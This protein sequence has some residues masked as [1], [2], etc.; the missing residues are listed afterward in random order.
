MDVHSATQ[1][2]YNMSQIRDKDTTPE[3]LIR[4]W[5]WRNGYR[6]RLH[7]KDLPGKPDIVFRK[8]RKVIFVHGCFWHKH[9]CDYFRWPQ[10]NASFWKD[11]ISSNVKR[12]EDMYSELETEGW[13]YLIIWEC[14]LRNDSFT[15]TCDRLVEFLSN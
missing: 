7:C 8:Q 2:S 9:N 4:R 1:R 13:H 5:L 14:E 3:V 12:D 15:C 6:Y 10:T 11:K